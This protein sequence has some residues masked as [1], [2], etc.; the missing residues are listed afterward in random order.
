MNNFLKQFTDE[1][2]V[3]I[4]H[5][6]N[7]EYGHNHHKLVNKLVVEEPLFKNVFC[8]GYNSN[9]QNNIKIRYD[10][11]EKEKM[12]DFYKYFNPSVGYPD[13]AYKPEEYIMVK[14]M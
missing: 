1:Y 7:G 12:F 14:E 8:Y 9:I 6:S 4:T 3:V 2:D 13:I 10:I 5:N 11:N